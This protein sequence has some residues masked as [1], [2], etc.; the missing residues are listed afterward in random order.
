MWRDRGRPPQKLVGV[1][2]T[3]QGPAQARPFRRAAVSHDPRAEWIFRGVDPDELIGDHPS[4]TASGNGAA[5]FELDRLDFA[6]GTPPHALLLAS[7]FEHAAGYQL[8]VED[9]GDQPT[10]ARMTAM[11]HRSVPD[12]VTGMTTDKIRSVSAAAS[13]TARPL[14]SATHRVLR[15]QDLCFY[16]GPRGGAVFSVG[17]I[18]WCGGLLVSGGRNTVAT[19]TENVIRRFEDP[20]PFVTGGAKM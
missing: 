14:P 11:P 13:S 12:A 9:L 20:R 5:G 4:L 7:S 18:S 1:G 6:L 15:W 16:E 10:G 3:S 8:C 19:V 2:F 17:S